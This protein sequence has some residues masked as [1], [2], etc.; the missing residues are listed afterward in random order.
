VSST[1]G[2]TSQTPAPA[3]EGVRGGGAAS[4]AP[5]AT[6]SSP[7]SSAGGA[8]GVTPKSTSGAAQA[9]GAES[10]AGPGDSEAHA[11]AAQPPASSP[12]ASTAGNAAA[13]HTTPAIAAAH[14]AKETSGAQAPGTQAAQATDQPR[15]ASVASPGQA[16]AGAEAPTG[17]QAPGAD[18]IRWAAPTQQQIEALRASVELA[19]R[20]GTSQAR[21]SLEPEELG[22]VNIRLT[23]TAAGLVARVSAQSAAGAQAIAAGQNDLRGLLGSLGVSLLHLDVGTSASNGRDAQWG[24]WEQPRRETTNTTSIEEAT[25][26][27]PVPTAGAGSQGS[28]H[29]RS[30]DVLA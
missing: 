23:Q 3:P 10:P 13:G 12:Q 11:P 9:P 6:S 29:L 16:S 18:G 14:G 17:S 1:P 7:Q 15:D 2:A 4:P 22:A 27:A 8:E 5:A 25:A 21:I 30:I 28:G 24:A 20:A 19:T 26:P